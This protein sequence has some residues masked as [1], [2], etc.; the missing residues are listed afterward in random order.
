MSRKSLES[1]VK[2]VDTKL[3]V[4]NARFIFSFFYWCA[5]YRIKCISGEIFKI[6]S[7]RMKVIFFRLT[8]CFLSLLVKNFDE[9]DVC[10]KVLKFLLTN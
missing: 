2:A 7:F 5:M 6:P 8:W 1:V 10:V 4:I 9:K 3:A